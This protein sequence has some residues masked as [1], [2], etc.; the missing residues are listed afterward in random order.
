MTAVLLLVKASLL[1]LATAV[2][3]V[4]AQRRAAAAT[5]HWI[6][7]LAVCGL[8]LLPVLSL[9]LPGWTAIP[10]SEGVATPLTDAP[11][12]TTDVPLSPIEPS[13]RGQTPFTFPVWPLMYAGGAAFLLAKIAG[14]H[15][16]VRRLVNRATPLDSPD[17][18]SLLEI[19]TRQ[20]QLRRRVRLLRTADETIPMAVGLWRHAIVMPAAADRWP[21]DVKRAVLVHELAHVGRRDCLTQLATAV[22]CALYWVHPAAWWLARRLRIERELACDD[23][24]VAT[25]IATHD[26]AGHLLEL[27]RRLRWRPLPALAVGMAAPRQLETRVLALLDSTRNRLPIGRHVRALGLAVFIA[28]MVPLAAA[29]AG[30]TQPTDL[31]A[32]TA[33]SATEWTLSPRSLQRLLTWDYWRVTAEIQLRRLV[34]QMQFLREMQ[35]LGYSAADPNVLLALRQHGVTPQVVRAFAA[36]GLSHLSTGDLLTAADR[37][38]TPRFVGEMKGLGYGVLDIAQLARLRSRGVSATFIGELQRLGYQKLTLD[39]LVRLRG[40][41]VDPKFIQ[42]FQALGY[43]D[44][45]PDAFTTLRSHGVSATDAQSANQRAGTQ[46]PVSELAAQAS[47]GWK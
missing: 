38:V 17:W 25:G 34:R 22:A 8:L 35:E 37:G 21:D 14:D 46:L 39:T 45:T 33:K 5:R 11:G 31:D 40:H 26:Y 2:V 20:L 19:S 43:A 16:R 24:V 44:L 12:V 28:T 9:I 18:R 15:V 3:V 32:A 13:F 10:R 41:G 1:L 7:A 6:C 42:E 30:A 36:A 4:S 29:T 47:R 23:R 27:G